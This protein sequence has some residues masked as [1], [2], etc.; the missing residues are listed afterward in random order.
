M[1]SANFPFM[2]RNPH[3]SSQKTVNQLVNTESTSGLGLKAAF[4]SP[5]QAISKMHSVECRECQYKNNSKDA[6]Y[7]KGNWLKASKTHS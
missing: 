6:A 4:H 7:D 5:A 3:S 1:T 2:A